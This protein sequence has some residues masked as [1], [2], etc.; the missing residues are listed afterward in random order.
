MA[1]RRLFELA[2]TVAITISLAFAVQSW[3]V[4]PYLI[5]SSSMEPTLKA[6]ERVLVDRLSERLGSDPEIGDVVVFHPPLGAVPEEQSP[7]G[8]LPECGAAQ[9]GAG[10]ARVCARPSGDPAGQS[11]IKRVVAGPGDRIKVLDGIPVVDGRRV[12]NGW[13]TVPCRAE[14]CSFPEAV[15]IP[16]GHYFLMGDNRPASSD[17]RVWGPVPREWIVGAAFATYWPPSRIGGL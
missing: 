5:P 11:F 2:F 9:S 14:A 4:K 3:A 1:R 12:G 13:E 6:G 10:T 7:T 8:S 15:E 17:S 16:P